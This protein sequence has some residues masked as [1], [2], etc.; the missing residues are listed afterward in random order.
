MLR[1]KES[2]WLP[3]VRERSIAAMMALIKDDLLALGI[4]HDVFF[5]E[6]SLS[7]KGADEIAETIKDLRHQDLVYEGRLPPPKGKPPEDW[8]DREQTLFRAT[9]FGDDTDRALLK[10]DG[11]YT[12]FAA[13][14]AYHRSKIRRGF[15]DMINVLGADHGGY[16]KR[17]QAAVKALSGGEGHVDVKICQLVRLFRGGEPVKMS[18]RSGSFVTLREVVD[19]VGPGAVRF[20]MLYRKNDAPL[21]FDFVRV[22]EQSRDNPVFYV[23]YAHARCCSVLRNAAGA[24]PQP[25]L[26]NESLSE[27][28]LTLLTDEAELA[29]IKRLAQ[30]PRAVEGAAAA[31]EPHRIA[32]YVYDLASDFH[33]LWNR[34]KE[35]PHLRFMV[36]T[37]RELTLA[38]VALITATASVIR[39]ALSL[40]GVQAITEMR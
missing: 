30:Y 1:M 36:Q 32:F 14:M 31:H 3:K 33:Q 29:L 21:D 9:A 24:G 39:S 6:S 17:L 37:S 12:Y 25:K 4:R 27:A 26:D 15:L 16:V 2:T 8:E 5:A 20:M 38:R 28:D 34:G 10:S 22:T 23:Q 11:S 19:E 13:D 35:L 40:L 18:K 7:T